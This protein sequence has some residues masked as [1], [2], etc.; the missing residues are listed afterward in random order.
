M[1]GLSI[2]SASASPLA[3]LDP[4]KGASTPRHQRLCDSG[5]RTN[6]Q[7][8]GMSPVSFIIDRVALAPSREELI[9]SDNRGGARAGQWANSLFSRGP[10]AGGDGSTAALSRAPCTRFLLSF[11]FDLLVS[12]RVASSNSGG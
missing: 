6:A 7:L 1:S 12:Y 3:S 2:R 9:F 4:V 5:R 10:A 11:R 8:I